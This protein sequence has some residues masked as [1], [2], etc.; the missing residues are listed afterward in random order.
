MITDVGNLKQKPSIYYLADTLEIQQKFCISSH[1]KR[2]I[3]MSIHGPVTG[4]GSISGLRVILTKVHWTLIGCFE[5]ILV[6][7]TYKD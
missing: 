4:T 6:Y 1:E 2:K 3:I 5:R 7:D